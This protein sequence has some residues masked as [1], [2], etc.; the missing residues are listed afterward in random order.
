MSVWTVGNRYFALGKLC[1][2]GRAYSFVLSGCF[3][4]GSFEF[5]FQTAL[6]LTFGVMCD[7]SRPRGRVFVVSVT[8][9]LPGRTA[10]LR[11][12]LRDLT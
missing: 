5:G 6:R 8:C 10:S 4:R 3:F 11:A 9:V 12:G 2:R 7:M 1:L